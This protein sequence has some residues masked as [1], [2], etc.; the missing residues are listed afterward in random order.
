MKKILEGL[1]AYNGNDTIV[2]KTKD[3][4]FEEGSFLDSNKI[5]YSLLRGIDAEKGLNIRG[6]KNE[7]NYNLFSYY[8][9]PGNNGYSLFS[10]CQ[11]Y[12]VEEDFR[13]NP[14]YVHFLLVDNS[15]EHRNVDIFKLPTFSRPTESLNRLARNE[16]SFM[17]IR[18][19]EVSRLLTPYSQGEF[20]ANKGQVNLLISMVLTAQK[21]GKTLYVCYELRNYRRFVDTFFLA[22][23]YLP[24]DIANSL[25][26][27]T[28]FGGGLT[29]KFN[30]VG[31]P[32]NYEEEIE[33]V[34][35]KQDGV[36]YHFPNEETPNKEFIDNILYQIINDAQDTVDLMKVDNFLYRRNQRYYQVDDYFRALNFYAN[37][38]KNI[39]YV[40]GEEDAFVSDLLN[41]LKVLK[42]NL[43]QI[44]NELDKEDANLLL[45]KISSAFLSFESMANFISNDS[46]RYNQYLEMIRLL[47]D[48]H[49]SSSQS[50]VKKGMLDN[51]YNLAFSFKIDY[52]NELMVNGHNELINYLFMDQR[53]FIGRIFLPYIYENKEDKTNRLMQ[54]NSL[55]SGLSS[56]NSKNYFSLILNYLFTHYAELHNP[57]SKVINTLSQLVDKYTILELVELIYNSPLS[58]ADQTNLLCRYIIT[59]NGEPRTQLINVSIEFFKQKGLLKE[60]LENIRSVN[61]QSYEMKILEPLRNGIIE[62]LIGIKE[63]KTYQELKTVINNLYVLEGSNDF[64]EVRDVIFDKHMS[65]FDVKTINVLTIQEIEE[66]EKETIDR[67]LV[68]LE[69]DNSSLAKAIKGAIE[70]RR[71]ERNR[72]VQAKE[73]ERIL[74]DLRVDFVTR[75]LCTLPEKQSKKVIK[76]NVFAMDFIERHNYKDLL[77]LKKGAYLERLE[78]F[79]RDIFTNEENVRDMD[80]LIKKRRTLAYEISQAKNKKVFNVKTV[81]SFAENVLAALL[82]A[83][84]TILLAG[85]VSYISYQSLTKQSYAFIYFILSLAAGACSFIM[86]LINMKNKGRNSARLISI[87]ES[88]AFVILFVGAFIVVSLIMGGR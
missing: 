78:E 46:S 15:L 10:K 12:P 28:A 53:D 55:R 80:G 34:G 39:K 67:L 63:I 9:L 16:E 13:G 40:V 17:D 35:F 59:Y 4:S 14:E 84:L 32:V 1:Y 70:E 43:Y 18:E 66:N 42:D 82:F 75:T 6:E 29:S 7:R 76:N 73:L 79:S 30:V 88:F 41:Q 24:K 68:L 83:G 60:A 37:L 45:E 56:E 47:I 74:I 51:L 23:R 77:S 27:I 44:E 49:N 62:A 57:A 64:N 58:F 87:A 31:V 5:M 50:F 36:V 25:S 19:D 20:I 69:R 48:I 26:F 71:E 65:S 22:M 33:R 11:L 86:T 54:E 72:Q 52:Q 38:T 61:F 81:T 3:I 8:Y 2:N 85:I 21:M